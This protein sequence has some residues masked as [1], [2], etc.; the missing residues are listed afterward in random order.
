MPIYLGLWPIA[1]I[2]LAF[3]ELHSRGSL[4]GN[5]SYPQAQAEKGQPPKTGTLQL[6]QGS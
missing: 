3:G 2:Y 4:R 1:Q 6:N 5:K